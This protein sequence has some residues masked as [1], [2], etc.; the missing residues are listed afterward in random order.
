MLEKCL[1]E[2]IKKYILYQTK[3]FLDSIVVIKS[4]L[5]S[6]DL[7]KELDSYSQ[8]SV[9]E[10][11][12]IALQILSGIVFIHDIDIIHRDLKPQNVFKARG[13]WKIGDFGQAKQS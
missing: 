5:A 6:S 13:V 3:L 10:N 1:T 7:K 4:E 12:R 2:S 8:R 11:I 9:R